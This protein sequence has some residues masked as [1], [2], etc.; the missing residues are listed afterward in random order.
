MKRIIPG[1]ALVLLGVPALFA[2][3]PAGQD[4][5]MMPDCAA[6]MKQHEAMQ[7][8]MAEMN[9][10]L[11]TMVDDMNTAKGSARVDKMA[12][13]INELVGQRAMMQKQM[14]EMQPKMMEHMMSHMK[15]GMMKGMADSMSD[16]PMMK[17]G[18]KVSET[19]A[20]H[21]H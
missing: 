19:P 13:V 3:M 14:M 2:Q 20:E 1:L 10:K 5:A 16:C 11:Q 17:G 9:T 15:S 18:D 21:K 6:M 12:A 7:T 8:H 4:K